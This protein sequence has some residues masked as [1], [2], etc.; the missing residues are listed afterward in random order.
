MSNIGVFSKTVWALGDIHGNPRVIRDFYKANEEEIDK[1]LINYLILLGDAGINYYI[2]ERDE[3]MKKELCKYPFIYFC[4]RGNHEQ[5]PSIL[6]EE[7][8]DEWHT[9]EMWGNT[10]YV[11]NKYPNIK[12]A[13]DT[14]AV[15]EIP[16][17]L[18][19]AGLR[20]D[21]PITGDIVW[22]DYMK[23][24]RTLVIP[25]AYSIDKDWRKIQGWSWFEQEQLSKEERTAGFK[26]I[27]ATNLC[28]DV[29]LSHTCPFA[30]EPV[31][32]FFP[33]M[34]QSKVDK[35]MEHYLDSIEGS[36]S[37]KAWLWGHYHKFR[38]YQVGANGKKKLMLFNDY[39]V[40]LAEYVMHDKEDEVT[41]PFYKRADGYKM[42]TTMWK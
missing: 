42:Y 1:Y 34:D 30:Y 17:I 16:Y 5:R 21:D 41:Y 33:G 10:V 28:V 38:D 31:D 23:T 20:D 29:V 4:V 32:L 22:E 35:T 14:V 25:G 27:E 39:A 9:E 3:R 26:T 36:I 13:L 6:M 11:E 18:I 12:Y 37:Y 2:N 24:F 7:N 8:P 40:N 15:Y 19:P